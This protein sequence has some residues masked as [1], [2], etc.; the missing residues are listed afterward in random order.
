MTHLIR[1]KKTPLISRLKPAYRHSGLAKLLRRLKGKTLHW[2]LYLILSCLALTGLLGYHYYQYCHLYAVRMDGVEIG[3]VRDPEEVEQFLA[4]LTDKSSSLYRMELFPKQEI[5]LTREYRPGESEDIQLA[6]NALMQRLSFLTDAVLVTV[7]GVPVAPVSKMEEVNRVVEGVCCAFVDK[8]NQ[9]EVLEVEL[10]EEI[11][12]E[13]CVVPPEQVYDPGEI[14]ALLTRQEYDQE[15]LVASRQMIA[16]RMG[17]SEPE[18]ETGP[19][20]PA[21][22]VRH[23]EKI[24]LKEEIPY[25]TKYAYTDK[26]YVGES[27]VVSPGKSGLKEVTYLVT[28]ENGMEKSREALSNR[29]IT[30]PEARVVERGTLK[31]FAWPVSGGGRISQYF[32]AGHRGIDIAAPLNKS[33]LAAESG[34]VTVSG[35]GSSQGNYIVINHGSYYTLYLHN[36]VNL[37]SAGQRVSRGQV[38]ARLGSTGNSTG[39]HLHFEIRRSI[40]SSWSGWYTHPAINPLQFY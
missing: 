21:V 13:K 1:N 23:V 31:R 17:R 29:V 20:V 3:L 9:V 12:G 10:L 35:W 37:V 38:I 39:P 6:R 36:N 28:C 7:D 5:T 34:V 32:H 22:H 25:T 4:E 27:R 11:S 16:S 26:M 18:E 19:A 15:L 14:V 40:G 2:S 8:E 33:I 24:T 30:E